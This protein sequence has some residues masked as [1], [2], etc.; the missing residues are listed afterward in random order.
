MHTLARNS[1]RSCGC[2]LRI[3]ER[4][5]AQGHGM[6]AEVFPDL[7]APARVSAAGL[8][9]NPFTGGCQGAWNDPLDLYDTGEGGDAAQCCGLTDRRGG[10]GSSLPTHSLQSSHGARASGSTTAKQP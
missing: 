6:L 7:A 8:E 10:L 4:A 2:R 1:A 3:S 9:A 5:S